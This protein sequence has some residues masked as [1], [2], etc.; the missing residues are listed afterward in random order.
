MFCYWEKVKSKCQKIFQNWFVFIYSWSFIVTKFQL[1]SYKYALRKRHNKKT[2]NLNKCWK[3]SLWKC[4][5]FTIFINW[6]VL[7]ILQ[8][9]RVI[10]LSR[11]ILVWQIHLFQEVRKLTKCLALLIWMQL[12]WC[13]GPGPWGPWGPWVPGSHG[14]RG[15]WGR[16]GA[17][18][19]LGRAGSRTAMSEP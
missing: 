7:E 13:D 4:H 15:P 11:E 9:G 19:A 1:K 18:G 16:A 3:I 6:N 2:G 12:G 8:N 5:V 10:E 17:G 14:S